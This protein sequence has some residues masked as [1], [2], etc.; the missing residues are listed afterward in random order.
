[1]DFLL[2]NY[3]NER[4]VGSNPDRDR[5]IAGH[6]REIFDFDSG[7]SLFKVE[8][9]RTVFPFLAMKATDGLP[10]EQSR[11]VIFSFSDPGGNFAG[12]TI[13]FRFEAGKWQVEVEAT[14]RVLAQEQG[15]WYRAPL[16]TELAL[17]PRGGTAR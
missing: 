3:Q 15:G 1:M 17:V 4:V 7:N 14:G 13:P 2:G 8:T 9:T 5:T 10:I 6:V 16:G 11:R 12:S